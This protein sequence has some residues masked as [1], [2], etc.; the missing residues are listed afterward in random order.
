M[1][2]VTFILLLTIGAVL[3]PLLDS[4]HV[5]YGV[6]AYPYATGPIPMAGWVI[7]EFGL[8]AVLVGWSHLWADRM[9]RRDQ[10]VL[11]SR[12]KTA[13]G[14]IGFSA[15]YI[16]SALL[17]PNGGL[18]A[19]VLILG[20]LTLWWAFDRTPQGILLAVITAVAGTSVESTL[21]HTG[22]FLYTSPDIAGVPYWLPLLYM[23]A[24]IGVGNLARALTKHP[25]SS[26]NR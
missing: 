25:G 18:T 14:L 11:L 13:V 9:L 16:L 8:A 4:F 1:N 12:S 24:S 5:F 17:Y 15:L 3:G 23:G 20:V 2:I 21:S 19:F 7:P 6:S 22:H 10:R 26:S